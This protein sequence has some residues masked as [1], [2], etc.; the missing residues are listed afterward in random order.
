ME[1]DSDKPEPLKQGLNP[2]ER[3]ESKSDTLADRGEKL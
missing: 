1:L 2:N 3:N